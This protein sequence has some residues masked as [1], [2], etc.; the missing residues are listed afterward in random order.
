VINYGS[1]KRE[2]V[3]YPNAGKYV[4]DAVKGK[5]G[6]LRK[7]HPYPATA[8]S[9]LCGMFRLHDKPCWLSLFKV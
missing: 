8:S 7:V 1:T 9:D 6:E 2:I 5:T 4:D 3:Y